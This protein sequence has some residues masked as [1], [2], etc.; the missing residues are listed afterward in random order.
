MIENFG[1]VIH[2]GAEDKT[3]ENIG[4]EKEAGYRQGL[5]EALEARG[6][7]E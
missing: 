1:I 4:P 6:L 3:R 5:A 7:S 2:G